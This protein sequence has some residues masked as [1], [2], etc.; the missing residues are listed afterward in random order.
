MKMKFNIFVLMLAVAAASAQGVTP[1]PP[2]GKTAAAPVQKTV[3]VAKKTMP[4]AKHASAKAAPVKKMA[5]P[6]AK[7]MPSPMAKK[8][9]SPMAKKMPAKKVVKKAAAPAPVAPELAQSMTAP[10]NTRRRDPFVSPV[11]ARLEGLTG[12]CSGGKRCLAVSEIVLRGIVKSMNGFIAVVE[13]SSQRTYFLH[14]NDPIFNGFVQKI[15]PD[16]VV[17]REHFIDNLG[18]DSQKEIVKTVNA[19]VV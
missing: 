17:F 7:K 4:G 5:S 1:K 13:N 8:L 6:V 3:T 12:A 19:P 16:S 18:H 11:Q 15:T 10:M 2:A 14:E 9:P